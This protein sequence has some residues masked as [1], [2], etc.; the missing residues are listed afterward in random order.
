M[1]TNFS[2][3]LI[4][5]HLQD[6]IRRFYKMRRPS[7]VLPKTAMMSKLHIGYS[8]IEVTHNMFL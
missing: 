3:E 7:I 5:L 1:D 6:D 2:E 8:G 4:C